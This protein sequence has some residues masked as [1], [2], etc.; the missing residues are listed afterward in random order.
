MT[1]FFT[2]DTHFGHK[3]IIAY[4]NR[5]FKDY[6]HMDRRIVDNWNSVVTPTDVVYHLG[7]VAMGLSDRW[8][9]ILKSLNGYKVL[10]VGNHDRVFKGMSKAQN[11][12]WE[13][14]YHEWFDEVYDNLRDFQLYDG[15]VVNLSHFPYDGDSHDGD[16]YTE[17]RLEDRG[18]VLIH[19]H[20]HAEY[21]KHGMDSR[22]SF[23]KSNTLQIHVGQDAWDYKPVPEAEVVSLIKEQANAEV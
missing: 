23:S 3:N 8:D 9:E 11:D 1:R 2:S 20:T 6:A 21:E 16:R 19:G 12:K 10:I 13:E 14:K 18:T 5:P 22:V 15:T 17:F 7:D 4:S